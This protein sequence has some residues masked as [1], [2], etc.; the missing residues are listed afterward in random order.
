MVSEKPGLKRKVYEPLQGQQGSTVAVHALKKHQRQSSSAISIVN[1]PPVLKS[2]KLNV[3]VFGSGSMGELGLGPDA[4]TKIVKRPRLNPHLPIDRI[5]V[6]DLAVGGMHCAVISHQ[7]KIY[8]W[9]VNDQGALGRD[10]TWQAL[11]K[12]MDAEESDVDSEESGLNPLEST[13][14]VIEGLKD[15]IVRVACGD[16]ISVAVTRSGDVYAWG[17]FRCADGILGFSSK[18][19]VALLP[20]HLSQLK[21]VCDVVTGTDH[22][23]AVTYTGQVYAWG[24]GQQFQL[25][26]RVVERTRMNGLV[27]REFG[28]KK[29]KFVGAGSYHSF[30]VDEKGVVFAWGL[31]QFGQCGVESSSGE[32]GAVVPSVTRVTSL[33]GYKIVQITGGEHHSAAV[34]AEG[35]LL[36]WGRLDA[37]QLGLAKDDIPASAVADFTGKPRFVPIPTKLNGLPP[38]AQVYCGSHHNIAIDRNGKAWSW[39]FGDTYQVGQG[40]PGDDF[41][42]PTM[43]DNTASR[44]AFMR[45]GGASAQFSI[46]CGTP[47]ETNGM[48]GFQNGH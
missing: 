42:I 47:L 9:G 1:A 11:S 32:D 15:P 16:S 27:P 31:N 28:L 37:H 5:G 35:D 45:Y 34:T 40:P 3:Y 39:G 43:I 29:I 46:L 26:R 25:G 48:N 36:M 38:I 41:E 6:V 12:D 30:A 2:E 33:E 17:T 13:P 20:V 10:T 22:V 21:N 14:A 24:N 19:R 18:H 44:T 23:L 4:N 8:T 7:G